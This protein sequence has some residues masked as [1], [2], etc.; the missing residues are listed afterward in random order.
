MQLTQIN[1]LVTTLLRH[2]TSHGKS[3]AQRH[4]SHILSACR[5]IISLESA[6][7]AVHVFHAFLRGSRCLISIG[8]SG[9]TV[10]TYLPCVIRS[11]DHVL[12][13]APSVSLSISKTMV[14][15][16]VCRLLCPELLALIRSR[17][18]MLLTG[19]SSLRTNMLLLYDLLLASCVSCTY[20]SSLI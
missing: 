10:R 2:S 9:A 3:F 7:G 19:F 17:T 6:W 4:R 5:V 20:G 11:E 12:N 14:A 8:S 18:L 15:S 13:I 16:L 1:G